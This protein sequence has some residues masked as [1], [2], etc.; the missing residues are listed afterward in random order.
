[1]EIPHVRGSERRTVRRSRWVLRLAAAAALA[2]S[3][4]TE[5]DAGAKH[6]SEE[7]ETRNV[8]GER[9][10]EVKELSALLDARFGGRR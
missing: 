2:P 6:A 5:T 1:M 7:G 3:L 10:D 4:A 9:R 8:A